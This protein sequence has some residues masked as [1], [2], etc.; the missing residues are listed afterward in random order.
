M[1]IPFLGCLGQGKDRES[2]VPFVS[3][4]WSLT[5]KK[6]TTTFGS[7]RTV[8]T[9]CELYVCLSQA[10]FEVSKILIVGAERVQW[11]RPLSISQHG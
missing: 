4:F 6:D 9:L 3:G 10:H 5:K 7:R 11:H 8:P 1:C 2:L